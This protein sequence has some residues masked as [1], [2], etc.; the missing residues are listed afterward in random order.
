M[1]NYELLKA[2]INEVIKANGRQEITGVVL[3]QVLLSMVNSL[4]AGYQCMGVAT[5][6]TNPGTPDQNVFYFATQAG[7]YTNFGAI[8]LQAGIS[9]LIWDGD[10]A[11][12]TWFTVD[13]TPTNNSQN[14][15]ASGAVFNALKL[16]GGAYDVTAHNSGATFASL[17][18]LLNSGNLNT[19]IPTEIRHGGM[20]IKFVQSSDNK[21]VQYRLTSSTFTTIVSE[22]QNQGIEETEA[23]AR[24]TIGQSI[25]SEATIV[26]G[27]SNEQRLYSGFIPAGTKVKVTLLSDVTADLIVITEQAQYASQTFYWGGVQANTPATRTVTTTIDVEHI[28]LWTSSSIAVNGNIDIQIEISTTDC[29][30]P[31]VASNTED[32]EKVEQ[33][34]LDILSV[35]PQGKEA[36][37][38]SFETHT[39][40]STSQTIFNGW[41]TRYSVEN[42]LVSSI[43]IWGNFAHPT[44]LS[45]PVVCEICRDD[46]TVLA[47]VQKNVASLSSTQQV[48]FKFETPINLNGNFFVRI[49]S[50]T[51]YVYTSKGSE[52]SSFCTA[53]SSYQ[54]KYRQVGSTWENL[55]DNPKS[56]SL[57]IVLNT[58]V[59]VNKQ[60]ETIINVG[61]Y[62]GADF[63]EIQD[64]INSVWTESQT[65]HYV[66]CV[67]PKSTPYK[68]FSMI[69]QSFS[70]SYP[71]SDSVPKNVSIIGLDVKNCIIESDKGDY[72][73]PAA[74]LLANGTIKNLHFRLTN[75]NHLAAS[76]EGG[77][78]AHIDSRTLN[79]M[80]YNMLIADCMFESETGPAVGIGLHSNVNLN[81]ERCK[82]INKA[83]PNYSPIE[84]YENLANWGCVFLHTS[85]VSTAVNQFASFIDCIGKNIYG[86]MSLWLSFVS[87]GSADGEITLMRNVFWENTRAIPGYSIDLRLNY[88]P[89]NYGN[90][91]PT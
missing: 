43:D 82:F 91:I 54:N 46:M 30:K 64:A 48:N 88:N 90:N 32:I 5:P 39:D 75:D 72:Y 35:L 78:A 14:L 81:F 52:V 83:N 18:A 17:S 74:E 24:Q 58:S 4:G 27:T 19:L 29:L 79:D 23:I 84:G 1:G 60:D 89:A 28:E 37:F 86:N 20:S 45:F 26:A 40:V 2:A 80:G 36:V 56:Y 85:T 50:D 57:D 77:Y 7:T 10:W 44:A 87:G 59:L 11:S 8:V 65:N 41:A 71:W 38:S 63:G 25:S 49:Y 9:V 47:S 6:S 61:D 34:V 76:T 12:Q 31:Q 3:N 15:I 66:I 62:D 13:S 33:Q 51:G 67:H 16:D 53:D 22:W 73:Y 70:L 42:K 55:N 21:Y 68:P 69:R